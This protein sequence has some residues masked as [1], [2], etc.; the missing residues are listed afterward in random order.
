MTLHLHEDTPLNREKLRRLVTEQRNRYR[1]TP[2]QRLTRRCGDDEQIS[3][4]I[5]LTDRTLHELFALC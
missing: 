2:D 4:S 1:V 5:A 3:S